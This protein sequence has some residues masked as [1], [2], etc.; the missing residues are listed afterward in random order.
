MGPGSVKTRSDLVVMPCGKTNVRAS[1]ALRLT[2]GLK[3]PDACIPR[4]VFT[5]PGPIPDI[6]TPRS[7]MGAR[8]WSNSRARRP[9]KH[10]HHGAADCCSGRFAVRHRR[11]SIRGLLLVPAARHARLQRLW[12]VHLTSSTDPSQTHGH[13]SPHC[14]FFRILSVA[15]FVA[16]SR[17]PDAIAGTSGSTPVP[18]QFVFEIG[19]IERANGTAITK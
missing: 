6:Q 17:A 14:H 1:G 7:R 5:Q 8:V 13:S 10:C 12:K 18:S 2:T 15:N 4:G 16:M 11:R 9:P 3:I 19:F